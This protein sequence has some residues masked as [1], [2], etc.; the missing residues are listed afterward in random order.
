MRRIL[1]K[2][3]SPFTIFTCAVIGELYYKEDYKILIMGNPVDDNFEMRVRESGFFQETCIFD[4]R[5]KTVQRIE[6]TVDEFLLKH[7][8]IDE[9]FLCVF[10]DG[11]SIMLA[12]RLQGKA[13]L[14]IFPEGCAT[15][16]LKSRISLVFNEVYGKDPLL[17][18]FFDKYKIDLNMFSRTWVFDS[19]IEQGDFKA[20]KKLIETRMLLESQ[21]R[22]E[23]VE[24]LN[25]LYGCRSKENYDI[26]ILD[27]VLA[28]SDL[29]EAE[30]EIKILDVLFE[31][32]K[33]KKILVKS[34]PGQDLL[35]SKLRFEKYGVDFYENPDIPW[36]II[37]INL[38]EAHKDGI[39]I[40][41]PLLATSVMSSISFFADL[42]PITI[43]SLHLLE[44]KFFGD[45]IKKAV[46]LNGNYYENAV[47]NNKNVRIFI[48]ENMS[49]LEVY[50]KK[51]NGEVAE[52][53][54]NRDLGQPSDF[55]FRVGNMLSKAIIFST[56]GQFY[57][58]SF[59]YFLSYHSEV[60][61]YV[62][63][64]IDINEFI[65]Q[66]SE[67]NIFSSVSGLLVMIEDEQGRMRE[68][69]LGDSLINQFFDN[70]K[71]VCHIKYKG[72]C[73]AIH[74]KGHLMIEH[75]FCALNW[76]YN[77]CKW[78]EKFWECW[79]EI[80]KKELLIKYVQEKSIKRVW[81]FGNGKI[82]QVISD[83]LELCHVKTKFIV[84]KI[85]DVK[86]DKVIAIE[87]LYRQKVLPDIMIITPMNDYDLILHRLS[88]DLKAVTVGLDKF[89]LE[90]K[91]E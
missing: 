74:I 79:Y 88:A 54:K 56:D 30:A 6:N 11:Y 82:G 17:R 59:F 85:S 76:L 58:K 1:F 27:D 37:L 68:Y 61:F 24:R 62:E 87:N 32:L 49:E 13:K 47:L 77:D 52:T 89:I 12:Y 66:P 19:Q 9:Y 55:F 63:K 38:M 14:N 72:Y 16:Q 39:T 90:V 29:L 84:S 69:I 36:E 15:L 81:V 34:H 8:K 26:F 28:A 20:E 51:I 43:L 53:R 40:I 71:M 45:Y 33:G 2:A 31:F 80:D 48:P 10:S 3:H 25:L 60:V 42:V 23:V 50:C 83:C 73:K 75:K 21:E 64:F 18:K 86:S 78:R 44:E 41:S 4:Q 70:G 91:G 46:Q 5:E 65:W 67:S 7:I 57:T 22:K 35:L